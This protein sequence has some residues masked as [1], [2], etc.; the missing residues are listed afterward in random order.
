M[1][2][3]IFD[4]VKGKFDE[5]STS[6]DDRVKEA[7]NNKD[8]KSGIFSSFIELVDEANETISKLLTEDKV[9]QQ[10]PKR[11]ISIG[12][13]V[14]GTLKPCNS[15]A[16]G[17]TG[18]ASTATAAGSSRSN[19]D[20][21]DD[22]YGYNLSDD[23]ESEYEEEDDEVGEMPNLRSPS[24]PPLRPQHVT[25]TTRNSPTSSMG[26]P[27]SRTNTTV[28]PATRT[29]ITVAPATRTNTTA[30]TTTRSNSTA[31]RTMSNMSPRGKGPADEKKLNLS[32]MNG[33][34][35]P[36]YGLPSV[37]LKPSEVCQ[38]RVTTTRRITEAD[39]DENSPLYRH[40]DQILGMETQKRESM[41]ADS[42][43]VSNCCSNFV[44]CRLVY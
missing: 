17:S 42:K 43:G 26:S 4:A 16:R 34:P 33:E 24:L 38:R 44:S 31:V 9:Q 15:T 21:D 32:D 25:P 40:R 7:R 18:G 30:T 12:A 5:L 22:L 19:L 10:L 29:N 35:L 41:A 28:A 14:A 8:E 11:S 3:D 13:P 1:F 27:T 23:E 6:V 37:Y 20:D 39:L 2:D 36:R